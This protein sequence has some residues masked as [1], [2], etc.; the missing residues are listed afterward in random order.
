ME[1]QELPGQ[2][3]ADRASGACHQNPLAR[4]DLLNLFVKRRYFDAVP[5]EK[6]LDANLP[7]V[8]DAHAPLYNFPQA[9]EDLGSD[10]DFL[11]LRSDLREELAARGRDA[12]HHLVD[13][14]LAHNL[15]QDLTSAQ[16]FGARDDSPD[17]L[18]I[19]VHEA[20]H[21]DVRKVIELLQE[22]DAGPSRAVKNHPLTSFVLRQRGLPTSLVKDS[23]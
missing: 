21:F 18:G 3:A 4:V 9:R 12:N 6:V 23:A 1:D 17:F 8:T 7:E 11:A 16:H 15:R 10:G 14:R 22:Q 2:F 19:I 13:L 20:N 5:A